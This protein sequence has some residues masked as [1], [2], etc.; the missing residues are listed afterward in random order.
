MKLQGDNAKVSTRALCNDRRKK[1]LL[2]TLL[3]STSRI[4]YL[5]NFFTRIVIPRAAAAAARKRKCTLSIRLCQLNL[6]T[7]NIRIKDA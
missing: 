7:Y 4:F 6:Y 2:Y 3:N 5:D 1:T